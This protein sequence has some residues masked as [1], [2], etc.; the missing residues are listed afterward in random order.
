MS[1]LLLPLGVVV[2]WGASYQMHPVRMAAHRLTTS[3]PAPL[4]RIHANKTYKR[5]ARVAP[6]W[7][8]SAVMTAHIK[9]LPLAHKHHDAA[10]SAFK[11]SPPNLVAAS[12]YETIVSCLHSFL[13]TLSIPS[14][15]VPAPRTHTVS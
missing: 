1:S 2:C 11:P 4:R 9:G 10:R 7:P 15:H 6:R 3:M 14:G 8:V 13:G 5:H 12:N